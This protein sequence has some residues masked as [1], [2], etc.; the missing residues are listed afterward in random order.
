VG[1][2]IGAVCFSVVE[3]NSGPFAEYL[4]QTFQS[5][6]L[7]DVLPTQMMEEM[8]LVETG[9]IRSPTKVKDMGKASGLERRHFG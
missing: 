1:N 9:K 7:F 3:K 5:Y 6:Q 2:N 8:T 4:K